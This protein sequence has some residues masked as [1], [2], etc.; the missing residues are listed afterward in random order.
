MA[1]APGPSCA[2]ARRPQSRDLNSATGLGIPPGGLEH[3]VD[4]RVPSRFVDTATLLFEIVVSG[5]G[6]APRVKK[7]SELALM[8]QIL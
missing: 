3:M 1:F 4:T 8:Y 5:P 7:T 6:V 2:R